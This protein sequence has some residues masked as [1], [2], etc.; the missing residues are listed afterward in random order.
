MGA[1]MEGLQREERRRQR[2]ALLVVLSCV[3][4]LGAWLTAPFGVVQLTRGDAAGWLLVAAGVV[5]LGV[6]LVGIL[7][8]RR[9][10]RAPQS[11]PGR[12]NARFDEPEPSQDPRGGF[13]MPG[14][15][16]GSH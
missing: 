13:S 10:H 11:V 9:S 1:L 4:G 7:A 12:P 14:S 2:V 16:L 8:A 15:Y 3:A 6:T 5:L